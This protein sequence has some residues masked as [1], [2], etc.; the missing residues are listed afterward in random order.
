MNAAV[1]GLIIIGAFLLCFGVTYLWALLRGVAKTRMRVITVLISAV[2]AV[3]STVIAKSM[4]ATEKVVSGVVVP[5][6]EH[7]NV[8]GVG[9]LIGMSATLNEVLLGCIGALIAPILCLCFF[10]IWCLITWI[11]FVIISLCLGE[12]M[13]RHNQKLSLK[14]LRILPWALAN[15]LIAFVILMVPVSV[16]TRI[17][18]VITTEL[19]NAQVMEGEANDA[20]QMI[21]EDYVEPIA[22]NPVTATY[23][24]MGGEALDHLIT[25]FNVRGNKT[26]LEDELGAVASFGCNVI[27]LS[28]TELAK[29]GEPEALVILALAD[30]FDR[31]ELLPTI[32]GEVIYNATDSWLSGET[33]LGI[34]KPDAGE[35]F[36]P[37]LNVILEIFHTDAQNTA[38]M[39]ADI[40]TLASMIST[41]AKHE[42]FAH[43]SNPNELIAK[44]D[45]AGAINDLVNCLGTNNS[46]K[47]LIPEITNLG[48]RAIAGT[49]GIP[50]DAVELHETF[51]NDLATDLN[52]LKNL[53]GE[54]RVDVLNEKLKSNFD[55]A[56][57]KAD[58]QILDCYSISIA[59]DLLDQAKGDITADDVRAFFVLY[60]MNANKEEQEE[61][62]DPTDPVSFTGFFAPELDEDVFKGTIYEKM[63]KEELAKTG[64]ATLAKVTVRLSTLEGEDLQV[65]AL[66]IVLSSYTD[67]LGAENENLEV[68]SRVTVTT[69]V[70][71]EVIE[72]TASLQSAEELDKTTIRVTVDKLVVKSEEVAELINSTNLEKEAEVIQSVISA[73]GEVLGN[74]ENMD[75]SNLNTI[76][77]SVGKVLDSLSESGSFGADQTADLFK[78]VLQSDTVREAADLDMETATNLS[79]KAT[80]TPDGGSVDYTGTL[81]SVSESITIVTQ[82]GKGEELKEEDLVSMIQNLTP[83]TA[84]MIEVYVTADRMT[85]YG[86]PANVAPLSASMISTLFGYLAEDEVEDFEAEAAALNQMLKI[87]MAAKDSKDKQLF[88]GILPSA[89]ETVNILLKSKAVQHSLKTNL[90]DGAKVTEFD[91]YGLGSNLDK[92]PHEVVEFTEALHAYHAQHPETDVLV[93]EAL[94][95]IFG[96]TVTF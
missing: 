33:F 3:I 87:G 67:L 42:V 20:L 35:L 28:R 66:S 83:A 48:I 81:G 5:L 74:T 34:E 4:I 38:A 86:V 44:L 23:R 26:H 8:E 10:W 70:S 82:M 90:T 76:A 94:A 32:V 55:K 22:E 75:M 89:T 65:Q 62:K 68:L 63:T 91:P 30:S 50:S 49:L 51:M 71:T 11:F 58:A 54:E 80:S 1:I 19:I 69:A 41:L 40:R 53:S 29:Y 25:D 61:D 95:A 37:F 77:S 2:L 45:G 17:A 92:A 27:K 12:G 57:I 43:L 79:D 7:F 84:G 9:E 56:G 18:P 14:P 46:M 73:A 85:G 96:I 47:V 60:A 93:L 78:A 39:Q 52:Q 64:A 6:L 13:K 24:S 36:N 88:N 15:T 72:G 21:V 16:Y 59:N 31:S